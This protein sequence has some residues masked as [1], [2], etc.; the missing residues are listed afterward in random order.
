MSDSS[1]GLAQLS[2]LVQVERAACV[3]F[4]LCAVKVTHWTGAVSENL[5]SG[6]DSDP[7]A[8]AVKGRIV[9]KPEP[10]SRCSA[11]RCL[12]RSAP[13]NGSTVLITGASFRLRSVGRCRRQHGAGGRLRQ[14]RWRR[15]EKLFVR[16]KDYL[17][18]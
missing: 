8:G 12:Q 2:C 4:P 5:S 18:A 7:Q 9:L 11:T 3:T 17:R 14:C 1:R 13:V 6:A 15:K 10:P 16:Q